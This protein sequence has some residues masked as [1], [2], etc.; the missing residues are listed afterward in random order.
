MGGR[1]F[2]TNREAA[3]RTDDPDFDAREAPSG[4]RAGPRAACVEPAE[5]ANWELPGG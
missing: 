3:D 4:A 5:D 2:S 1:T